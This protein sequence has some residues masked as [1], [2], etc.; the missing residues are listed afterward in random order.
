[1]WA[2]PPRAAATRLAS[3]EV[4]PNAVHGYDPGFRG[5]VRHDNRSR[6]QDRT[7]S[8]CVC[9]ARQIVWIIAQSSIF[10]LDG[11]LHR[12]SVPV[13]A[14]TSPQVISCARCASDESSTLF[15][16]GS[17][18]FRLTVPPTYRRAQAGQA[19]SSADVSH[20]RPNCCKGDLDMRLLMNHEPT[21]QIGV[22]ITIAWTVI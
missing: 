16:Y 4:K 5:P 13:A 20:G 10:L 19:N 14:Y 3:A 9:A 21:A 22:R 15:R 1:M 6:T 12:L 17:G 18:C 2:E 8:L 11:I 7:E